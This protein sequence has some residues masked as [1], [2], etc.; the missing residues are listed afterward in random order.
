[1]QHARKSEQRGWKESD[2]K[3]RCRENDECSEEKWGEDE[4]RSK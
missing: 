3:R 1:V 2:A 4:E